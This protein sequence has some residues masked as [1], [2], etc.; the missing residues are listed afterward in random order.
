VLTLTPFAGF[1][2]A[3][4]I[5]WALTPTVRRIAIRLGA[6][7]LR[8]TAK[9]HTADVPRLGGV[10]VAIAFYLPVLVLA[11]R[12]NLFANRLY[13]DPP[14]IIALLGGGLVILAL[15]VW[16]DLH[17]LSAAQKL[18]VQIPVAVA[19]WWAG[20]RIGGTTE[21]SG[22]LFAFGPGL[23]LVAT[24]IWI[25]GVVNALNLID[26]LDGLASGIAF[27][28][29]VA[30]ALCA[31]HRDEPVLAL[32]SI[33]LSGAVGGFLVHNFHPASV[34]MGDSGSM[35]LGFVIATAS[36][37][38]SQKG[39]TAVGVVLPAVALGLPLL[40]TSLAVWR[41]FAARKNV[42]IGDLDHIHH[43]FLARGWP[44]EATVLVLYGI[45][46]V[47]SGLSVLLI[48]TNDR[49]LQWPVA[50]VA[51]GLAVELSHWLGYLGRRR[52]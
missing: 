25:V 2:V 1:A 17:G 50:I 51:L 40:D 29:L 38:S 44:Y 31:W 15:G 37:W 13:A 49:R 3:F 5:A 27:Q 43:R 28:A 30:T 7:D 10:A 22:Q 47:F 41:R 20:L 21:L 46:L 8:S 26:G 24:V 14:H 32:M 34:F 39:A 45:G 23:S 11:L 18:A 33:V 4:A 16:D 19:V 12:V 9:I 35:F 6:V 52:P 36:I 42:F 48:Y